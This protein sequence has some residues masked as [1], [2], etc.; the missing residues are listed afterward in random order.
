MLLHLLLCCFSIFAVIETGFAQQKPN[1]LLILVDDLGYHDLGFNGSKIY[2]TPNADKL[3]AA[4]VS[5][6]NAYAN[7]PRCVPSRYAIM[8][9]SWPLKG[10]VVPDDGAALE[11]PPI[12]NNCVKLLKQEGY[13][14]GFF[15]KWHLGEG[16]NGPT[17][18][19]YDVSVAAGKAGSPISYLYPFNTPKGANRKVVKEPI[20]DLEEKAVEGD[21]LTDVLTDQLIN[22]VRDTASDQPFMAVLSFYA[23]H[24]PLEAKTQD[25]EKNREE[26]EGFDFG[27]Q[28]EYLSEGTGRTKMRQD[29]PIYAAM[30]EN[31]DWNLGR[32]LEVLKAQELEEHTIVIFSSDHGGL[33]NDGYNQ[34]NLAT[35][36]FP[37]RA[38]KGWMYEG[39]IRV[40][41][42][43][44]DPSLTPRRD[45]Q[46]IVLLMDVF[47]TILERVGGKA[48]VKLDGKS[49]YGV[50]RQE[51][52]WQDRTVFWHAEK[53]RPRQ[54]GESPA[55][56]IRSGDWKLI[57]F[58]EANKIELY[59]L[60][61]DPFEKN[62]LFAIYPERTKTLLN[63]LNSWKSLQ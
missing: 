23:V 28:P 18:M 17:N 4:S 21:F 43:V 25:V 49:F 22:F 9:A 3:A 38:G 57:N 55:S 47:P 26:I 13:R 19:G 41:L 39:G 10:S 58:Y 2:Q 12:E 31:M 53:A 30:V 5:F 36:N 6:S 50:L 34:R 16:D 11:I 61:S 52:N 1:V 7:Y 15:G 59:N 62:N 42:L 35:S 44:R 63:Q 51:E 29:N 20:P 24:Q 33:S 27:D 60:K 56:A 46:S 14:T 40:P 54:T 48:P 45:T 8:T 37:L 32:I